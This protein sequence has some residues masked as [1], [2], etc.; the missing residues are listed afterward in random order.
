MSTKFKF[1]G[2]FYE[3][4]AHKC[5]KYLDIKRIGSSKSEP[6]LMVVM[7]NPGS[8]YPLNHI[9][10]NSL[11][12]EARPDNTQR[13][14][15]K[16]M[17]SGNI[18]Y[19]R[20]LNLSDLRKSDSNKLYKFIKSEKSKLVDHSIFAPAR[21]ADLEQ[22]F[23]K[24]VPVIFGWGVNSVI[25]PLA[26]QAVES[27]SIETP[28]GISKDKSKYSYYHPLPKT[29]KKQIEWVEHVASQLTLHLL[30]LNAQKARANY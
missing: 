7:M 4:S 29:Y 20:V 22:L 10:N 11:P 27:L 16:V 2:L 25:M 9:D 17:D 14:I 23:V 21:K 24:N 12:T 1:M 19:A 6:E 15:T 5:R 8:S 18:D 13:Q 26:K 3:E 28:L 30:A